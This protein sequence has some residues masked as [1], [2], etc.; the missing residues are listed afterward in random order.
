MMYDSIVGR[1]HP[2]GSITSFSPIP[3]KLQDVGCIMRICKIIGCENKHI[4][5]GYCNK[6]YLKF[7]EYGDPHYKKNEQHGMR[8]TSE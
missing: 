5:K 8:H 6:H 1:R 4:A 2:G 3:T 7:W